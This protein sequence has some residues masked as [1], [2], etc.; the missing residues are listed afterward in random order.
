MKTLTAIL[1]SLFLFAP[2]MAAAEVAPEDSKQIDQVAGTFFDALNAHK[3]EEAYAGL[4][5]PLISEQQAAMRNLYGITDQVVAY[6]DKPFKY[7]KVEE[8]TLGSRLVYRKYVLYNDKLPYV[9]TTVFFKT[10]LGWK[11]QR[12]YLADLTDQDVSN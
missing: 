6:F 12:I 1:L 2:L 11:C 3:T 10:T 8:R 4:M 9:V 7:E 5:L